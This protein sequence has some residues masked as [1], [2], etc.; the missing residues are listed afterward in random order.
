MAQDRA[1]GGSIMFDQKE[2]SYHRIKEIKNYKVRNRYTRL[3]GKNSFR[4]EHGY[5]EEFLVKMIF[6]DQGVRG[7]GLAP[8]CP[9]SGKRERDEPLIGKKVSDVFDSS[10]GILSEEWRDYDFALHDLAG[11]ILNIPVFRMLGAEGENPVACYDGAILMDDLSP[12]EKPGGLGAILDECRK[13][14]ELGYRDFKLKIGRAPKWMDWKDGLKRDIEVTRLVREYY[15]E[16]KIMVDANSVYTVEKMKEYINAV[17]DCHL[18][19]IEE[20]FLEDREKDRQLREYLDQKMPGTWI[21]DGEADPDVPFLISMAEEGILD[22]I[23]MDIAGYGL[24]N[25]RKLLPQLKEKKVKISPHNWG[26]KVKTHYTAALAA[27]YPY[28]PSI[29]GVLDE[30]EGV[31]FTGYGLKNGKLSVPDT[32]GF[33]MGFIWGMEL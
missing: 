10:T 6:T 13:D 29:E 32:P 8:G 17:S 14:Y 24:T 26:L 25:W 33:G 22:V 16:A 23:Q 3:N 31:D 7:W 15:P 18:Y 9:V 19:W 27:A 12:D 2:L 5:G 21:A 1:E 28:T 11:R 4:G 20:P 30:T